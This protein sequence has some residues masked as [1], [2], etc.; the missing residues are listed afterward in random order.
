MRFLSVAQIII[1][2]KANEYK[3]T[4][5]RSTKYKMPVFGMVERGGNLIA[6]VVKDT[7]AKSL[8]PLIKANVDADVHIMTDEWGAY[9]SLHKS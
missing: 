3:R 5:G 2:I 8:I 1:D 7:T 6:Q 4:Q 9:N